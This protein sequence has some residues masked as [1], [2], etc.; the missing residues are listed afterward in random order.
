MNT[1]TI[2]QAQFF[3]GYVGGA[4]TI[5]VFTTNNPAMIFMGAIAIAVSAVG[6]M[7]VERHA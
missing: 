1:K 5:V 4:A 2:S 3:L 7:V 6:S